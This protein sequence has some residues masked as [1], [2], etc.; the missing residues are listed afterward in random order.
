[1]RAVPSAG[2]KHVHLP[3]FSNKPTL[4]SHPN[5]PLHQTTFPAKAD[6]RVKDVNGNRKYARLFWCAD[7]A[8]RSEPH[9]V[10]A[11]TTTP[12]TTR[13]CHYHH[14][15]LSL[16]H[17]VVGA[18]KHYSYYLLVSSISFWMAR[19]WVMKACRQP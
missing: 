10:T 6:K 4:P 1:M 5:I 8:H 12:Y 13:A 16:F 2:A 18:S 17:S 14:T 7:G 9:F 11:T 19:R 3:Y 15:H